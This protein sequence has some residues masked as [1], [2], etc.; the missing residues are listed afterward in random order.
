ML[1]FHECIFHLLHY[2]GWG[3]NPKLSFFSLKVQQEKA[4]WCYF[5]CTRSCSAP[6]CPGTQL[7]KSILDVP[8]SIEISRKFLLFFLLTK[9]LQFQNTTVF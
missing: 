9:T 3:K 6:V 8:H 4:P 7:L 5:S 2:F 1:L